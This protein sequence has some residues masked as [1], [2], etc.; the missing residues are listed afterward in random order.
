MVATR[1]KAQ[2][3]TDNCTL[4][5]QQTGNSTLSS[6]ISGTGN[7]TKANSGGLTLSAAGNT[8]T[9]KVSATGGTLTI[10][11][12]ETALG[13]APGSFV[14]DQLTLDGATLALGTAASFSLSANRGITLGSGGATITMSSK[15]LTIPGIIAGPALSQNWEP[16]RCF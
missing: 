4:S 2:L 16:R 8:F 14:A 7:I 5:L 9:G 12:A 6:V 1:T 3:I 13:A 10:N 11:N 15:N